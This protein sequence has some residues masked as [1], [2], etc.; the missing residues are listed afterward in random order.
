MFGIFKTTEQMG[1]LQSGGVGKSET[2]RTLTWQ[3][4]D[5]LF[6]FVLKQIMEASAAPDSRNAT[7]I[8]IIFFK[9]FSKK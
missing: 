3:C 4:P 2:K 6:L 7:Y 5:Y 9:T 1:Y 8:G